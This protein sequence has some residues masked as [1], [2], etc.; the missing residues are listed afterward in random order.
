MIKDRFD[1]RFLCYMH[2][3]EYDFDQRRGRLYL[4]GY[5][6]GPAVVKLFTAIDRE[7]V[8]IDTFE[9][10]RPDLAHIKEDGEW[11][12]YRFSAVVTKKVI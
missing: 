5:P 1:R 12:T 8:R 7:V 4:G 9:G 11:K 2:K 6:H 10:E 3:L